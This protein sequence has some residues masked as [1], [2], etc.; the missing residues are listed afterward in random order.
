MHRVWLVDVEPTTSV[1]V[2]SV[3]LTGVY[4][5]IEGRTGVGQLYQVLF[6]SR[7]HTTGEEVVIYVPLRVESDW[8]GTLRCCHLERALFEKKFVFV[9]E[10]LPDPVM[11]QS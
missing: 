9:S 2:E 5:K 1:V 3:M 10:G 4:R 8:A 7:H 11:K 6:P